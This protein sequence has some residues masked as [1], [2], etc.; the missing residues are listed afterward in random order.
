MPP[1]PIFFLTLVVFLAFRFQENLLKT[2]IQL[3]NTFFDLAE[4]CNQNCLVICDRGVMDASACNVFSKLRKLHQER[5]SILYFSLLTRLLAR[6]L[7]EGVQFWYDTSTVRGGGVEKTFLWKT[8]EVYV[9]SCQ[10]LFQARNFSNTLVFV[11]LCRYASLLNYDIF[12]QSDTS[13]HQI[14]QTV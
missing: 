13:H 10:Y 8:F 2:I 7:K 11:S 5:Y 3:E 14:D 4:S 6:V 1:N 9:T 12:I